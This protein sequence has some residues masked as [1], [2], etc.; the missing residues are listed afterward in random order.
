MYV[1]YIF[2]PK[3]RKFFWKI[4]SFYTHYTSS[5]PSYQLVPGPLSGPE[6]VAPHLE[7]ALD[8]QL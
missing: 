4:L 5:V 7:S 8:E 3:G 1:Y 2:S 6:L